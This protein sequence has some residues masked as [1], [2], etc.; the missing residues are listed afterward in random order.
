MLHH[1]VLFRFGNSRFIAG[2]DS[3]GLDSRQL[4]Q[5]AIAN[6]VRHAQTRRAGLLGPE[7][8]ARTAQLE[9]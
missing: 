5:L 6:E 9:I 2:N 7:E 1:D 8:L 4:E 3:L